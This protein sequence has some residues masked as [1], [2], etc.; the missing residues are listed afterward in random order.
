ME[1]AKGEIRFYSEKDDYGYFCNYY[2]APIEV[3]GR[4]W[5]TSEHYYQ[6]MK[7]LD[8]EV[9]GKVRKAET[10]KKAKGLGRNK[11]H[12]LREDWDQVKDDVMY[13]ALTAKF[14]QH[15]DLQQYLLETNAKR[16]VEHT[17]RDSYWGDGG[18]GS[19][20][21]KLGVLL[22]RVREAIKEKSL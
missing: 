22:M 20:Q 11:D 17:D 3:E 10:P 6:G 18:D 9:Q 19:G 15:S 21:N 2:A 7:F 4:V 12:H 5:P 14:T 1:G 8:A 16:L 13:E